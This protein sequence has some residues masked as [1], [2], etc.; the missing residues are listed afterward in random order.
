MYD[1]FFISDG[2]TSDNSF[3]NL[4]KRFP[5]VRK[6]SSFT[7]AQKKTFT[8]FFWIVW[9]NVEIND[10]FDFNY[11]VSEWNKSDIHVF[12]NGE[13]YDGV[14]LFP[15]TVKVSEREVN[16]RFFVNKKEVDIQASTSKKYDRFYINTYEEYLE[17]IEKTTTDMF[18]VVPDG[19][20]L[21]EEFTFN[22]HVPFYDTFHR[23]I[24]H[25]FKNGEYYDGICLFPKHAVITKKEFDHRFFVN[26]KEVDIQASIPAPFDVVFISYNEPNADENWNDLLLKVP[27]AKRIHGVKGIH[28]AHIAAAN[29][30]TTPMFW[31][32]DGDAKTLESFNFNY[33]VPVHNYD[34]VYVWKSR[35]PINDLEYGYGGIKL[36]PR[37]LTRKLDTRTTDMTTS[38]SSKFNA[39][40]QVSNVTVFNTDEFNTWKS[41]FRE[42]V[43]LSSRVIDGQITEESENRLNIWCSQDNGAPHGKMA[44]AGAKAGRKY[45]QE[46]AAN[47]AALYLINDFDWLTAQFNLQ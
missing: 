10:F 1:I 35:N 19:I 7:E 36:L 25:V 27:K 8:K 21:D 2:T 11:V 37:A 5:L 23:N 17:A 15:K 6:V 40:N 34:S 16:H 18:W 32:V 20:V 28:N 38:I 24:T 44:I 33:Q 43:K 45:G 30:A 42:C 41:A 46:N 9:N 4:K 14:C 29:I 31:V 13:Y 39:V 47:P 12:K 22:Y 26:K 3:D